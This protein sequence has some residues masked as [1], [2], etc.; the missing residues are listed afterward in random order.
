MKLQIIEKS[1][2]QSRG[3]G[4]RTPVVTF[5]INNFDISIN[6]NWFFGHNKKIYTVN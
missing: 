3:I 5:D 2:T 1:H 6:L 4:F